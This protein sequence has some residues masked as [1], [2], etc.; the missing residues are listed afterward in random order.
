MKNADVMELANMIAP[1][2]PKVFVMLEWDGDRWDVEFDHNGRAY[3]AIA[4]PLWHRMRDVYYME[5]GVDFGK[6]GLDVQSYRGEYV[7][8]GDMQEPP[9]L[10]ESPPDPD[11][12][13]RVVA[14]DAFPIAA[15]ERLGYRMHG[16]VRQAC[17]K[18]AAHAG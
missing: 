10:S 9:S 8:V 4:A 6:A 5:K 18:I 14:H 13:L 17:G 7:V 3:Y 15:R 2:P 12:A 1:P 16:A 11:S